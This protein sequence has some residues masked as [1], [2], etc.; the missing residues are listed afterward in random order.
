MLSIYL[1]SRTCIY[2]SLAVDNGVP[3]TSKRREKSQFR[4]FFPSYVFFLSFV[5]FS[6]GKL[7]MCLASCCSC[8][9][10]R[11]VQLSTR[12]GTRT[13]VPFFA[14][15]PSLVDNLSSKWMNGM[16]MQM[17]DPAAL[18]VLGNEIQDE[19]ETIM[20]IANHPKVICFLPV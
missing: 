7:E 6:R 9:H 4:V 2:L 20:L 1:S 10:K 14:S 17:L 3:M 15:I 13:V 8:C 11:K 5:L 19:Y 12:A 16:L 18:T